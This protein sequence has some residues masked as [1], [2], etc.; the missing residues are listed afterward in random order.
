MFY[1]E[2]A[3]AKTQPQFILVYLNAQWRENLRIISEEASNE[4]VCMF[5]TRN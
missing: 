2:T 1:I 3:A 4:N 5:Q